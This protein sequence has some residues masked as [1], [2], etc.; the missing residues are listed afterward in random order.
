LTTLS[1]VA[2]VTVIEDDHRIR[3]ALVRALTIR[4]HTVVDFSKGFDGL[5]SVV[6]APPDVLV[7]D[8]GLPDI[9]GRDLLI[10]LRKVSSIPVIVVTARDDDQEVVS[11]LHAGADDY[12]IKP[13][14]AEQLDARIVALLR[15]TRT[16][17]GTPIIEVGGLRI[18]PRHHLVT[19]DGVSVDLNR[20]EFE[21]LA[22][23]AARPG[24]VTSKQEL[25]AEVWRQPW[26]G[27]EKTV[28]VH[29]SWL[30]RK[31]GETAQEPRYLAAVRG[32]GVKL[33]APT[34]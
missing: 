27:S 14:S 20:K 32:V 2:N 13:F 30:R 29:L 31:L 15:R 1:A 7:L 22:Y 4:G 25:L 16:P 11:T 18:D 19:I 28:D 6:E 23:L 5:Q 21:L 26:G 17:E 9:D 33:V 8:L 12:I 3:E 34:S 10:E 24:V